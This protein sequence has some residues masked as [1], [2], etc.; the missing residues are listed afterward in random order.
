MYLIQFD[1]VDGTILG[2]NSFFLLNE[3]S[4]WYSVSKEAYDFIVENNGEYVVD[5][6]SA[7]FEEAV[8]EYKAA[9]GVIQTNAEKLSDFTD[10]KGRRRLEEEIGL[11]QE[12]KQKYEEYEAHA[13]TLLN[14]TGNSLIIPEESIFTPEDEAALGEKTALKDSLLALDKAI[15]ALPVVVDTSRLTM[16]VP[17]LREVINSKIN[18]NTAYCHMLIENGIEYSFS[19][20]VE[21]HFTFKEEDQLNYAETAKMA[22]SGLREVLI[23]GTEEK[24]YFTV[25]AA[26]FLGLY[27]ELIRNKY[28]QLYYLREYNK[29]IN[30][31]TD[32]NDIQRLQYEIILP[33]PYRSRVDEQMKKMGFGSDE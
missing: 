18:K 26:E 5:K 4:D 32:I 22:E 29:Y 15:E 7:G 30:S 8:S 21:R 27:R 28:Y 20:G 23:R 33:E 2:L 17:S 24:E 6:N 13:K 9:A 10:I 25:S 12:K 3:I 16:P 11:L 14:E 1:P 19:D 31:L